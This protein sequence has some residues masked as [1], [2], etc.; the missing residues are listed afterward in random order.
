MIA[1]D[2]R[3]M[4]RDE[5]QSYIVEKA[6]ENGSDPMAVGKTVRFV[7]SVIKLQN[8]YSR[9]VYV[10]EVSPDISRADVSYIDDA[11][12]SVGVACVLVPSK[13]M[14]YVGEVDAESF[15]VSSFMDDY[16]KGMAEDGR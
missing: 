16:M 5:F 7:E 8:D 12:K 1:S 4:T 15:G 9:P 6:R 13:S 10:F 11:M 14:R 2:K 3:V